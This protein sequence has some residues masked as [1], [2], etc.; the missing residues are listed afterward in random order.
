M[1]KAMQ[2][3]S[4]R[5]SQDTVARLDEIA[6]NQERSRSEIINEAVDGYLN[7]MAWFKAKIQEAE[8]DIA[9]GNVI[10]HE[11]LKAELRAKGLYVD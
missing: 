9:S 10:S 3:V 6:G 5:F 11:D 7:S 2:V 8:D 4:T 1:S